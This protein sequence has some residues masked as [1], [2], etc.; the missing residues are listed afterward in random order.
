M[1]RPIVLLVLVT[2]AS[3]LAYSASAGED[4]ALSPN[5]IQL[6]LEANVRFLADDLLEGRATPSRGLD[7]AALYLASE[8]RAAGWQPGNGESYLQLY[9]VGTYQPPETKR[10]VRISGQELRPDE[11]FL[12][13][14][15]PARGNGRFP[16][17]YAGYGVV[18]PERNRDDLKGI[19]LRGKGTVALFGAPWPLDPEGLHDW[20][21]GLGKSL[22]ASLRGARVSIYVSPEFDSPKEK[23]ASVEVDISR[24]AEPMPVSFLTE[25]AGRRVTPFVDASIVLRISA[26]DRVLAKACGG[27]YE[28]LSKRL[29]SGKWGGA[30]T[31][32]AAVEIEFQPKIAT[33]K[34]ANVVAILPGDDPELSREWIVLSA[35]YDHLGLVAAGSDSDRVYNGADDNASGCAAVLEV[36][37]R[38]AG[39]PPLKR[40]VLILFTSGEEAGLLGAL[41]YS[42][43]PLVERAQVVCNVNLDMVGRSNGT[44]SA[45]A[46]VSSDLFEA[47]AEASEASGIQLIPDAYPAKRLIYFVD[48]YA[49]A[50]AGVPAIEY[51]TAM[52]ADYHQPSDEASKID[53]DRLAKITCAAEELVA[54]YGRG[55]ARPRYAP[56]PWFIIPE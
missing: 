9:E 56:P 1:K 42:L 19:D 48:S 31:V 14:A 25:E 28:E 52:H 11:Y 20:D 21:R 50:R 8:L 30:R 32:D 34:A 10:L 17:V 3:G 16:L 18:A 40:S 36:A 41:H 49:F 43:H 38:L 24:Q 13:T 6:R 27:T 33:G 12:F 51:F 22:Q 39:S 5:A 37:R 55:S 29:A 2:A 15:D 54:L 4:L 47:A 23:P 35:H 7:M 46:A 53:W 44:A 45:I 26:F